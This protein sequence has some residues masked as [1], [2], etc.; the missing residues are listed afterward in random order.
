MSLPLPVKRV[1]VI[2]LAAVAAGS[3]Y[4]YA[5]DAGRAAHQTTTDAYVTA[6][7]TLVAPKVAGSIAQVFVE[8]NE[9]VVKG[10]LLATI[11][12]RDF[13]VA[14]ASAK[15]DVDNAQADV[16]RLQASIAQQTSVIQQAV[17]AIAADSASVKFAE[18][19]D[20]RYSNLSAD[21]SGTVQEQQQADSQLRIAIAR[22]TQSSAGRDAVEHQVT[23]LL[24]EQ[25]QAEA[26]AA[27]AMAAL[28]A[29]RLNLSYTKIFAPI[30]GTVGQRTLRVGAYVHVGIPLLAVVPLQRAYIEA[31]FLET[32]LERLRP[33]Q[34]VTIKV[35]MLSGMTIRGHVNS[36]APA[37]GITFSPIAPDNATGNFTKVVQRLP[38]KITIDPGQPAAQS[39]R[40]GMSVV[41]T[42][43]VESVQAKG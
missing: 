11:D 23:V 18:A 35:D 27:K 9:H 39:L 2:V 42:V 16:Q 28:D 12:D 17:A 20:R 13:V 5:R 14:V 40:V 26:R 6:D 38:V 8:E 29:A 30:D 43:D 15:A 32:Q 22:R 36:V 34:A 1:V 4:L 31:N 25:K 37:S 41:P 7:S 21:G 10:Q 24:A 3:L 33:G 19:N